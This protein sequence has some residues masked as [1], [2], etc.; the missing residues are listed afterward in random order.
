[1]KQGDV[2]YEHLREDIVEM[3]LAPGSVLNEVELTE[4][5]SVSRTPLREAI[6]RLAREGLVHTTHGRGTTVAEISLDDVVK[7][8]QMREA[9]EPYAARLCAR[10][11]NR[12]VFEGLRVELEQCRNDLY[13]GAA[14]DKYAGYYEHNTRFDDALAE[15]ADNHYLAAALLE[16]RGH[17]YR[18]RRLA[19][20]RPDRM[21]ATTDE[22]LAICNAICEGDEVLAVQAASVHIHNSFRNILAAL[23]EN[24]V[25]P[26]L[27]GP[28]PPTVTD[29][30]D[31]VDDG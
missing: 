16:L 26:G 29:Q 23:M 28:L 20:R 10:R 25:G 22:H 8:V 4:R 6:Q 18:L 17:L 13:A 24:V 14:E 30:L 1:M 11:S 2:V 3:R 27:L 15:G 9:L 21:V 5:L 31:Q 12:S 19:R 7:L